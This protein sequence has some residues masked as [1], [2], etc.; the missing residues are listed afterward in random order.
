VDEALRVRGSFHDSPGVTGN[1]KIEGI[2]AIALYALPFDTISEP[3]RTGNKL[4]RNS[5]LPR[6]YE[7]YYVEI[8]V[9]QGEIDRLDIL[10]IDK[11]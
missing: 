9:E 3:L 4:N 2:A 11:K 1:M 6:A 10:E 8:F 7:N 5:F